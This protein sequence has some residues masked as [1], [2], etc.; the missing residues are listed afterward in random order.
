MSVRVCPLRRQMFLFAAIRVRGDALANSGEENNCAK[1]CS[2][3]VCMEVFSVKFAKR[4]RGVCEDED[5]V[6]CG[7]C[8]HKAS[9]Q[10]TEMCRRTG[11]RVEHGR[12]RIVSAG[13][14]WTV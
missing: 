3:Q 7:S 5:S 4:A 11:R 12:S 14:D 8:I 6:S 9:K 10:C 13:S 1:N 2:G